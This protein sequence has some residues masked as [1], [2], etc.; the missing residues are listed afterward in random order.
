MHFLRIYNIIWGLAVKRKDKK[1]RQSKIG[2]LFLSVLGPEEKENVEQTKDQKKKKKKK[3]KCFK[4]SKKVK[5]TQQFKC[6]CGGNQFRFLCFW[7]SFILSSFVFSI[8]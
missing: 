5:F 4:C 2:S 1:S 8:I 3:A 7:Y 6:R